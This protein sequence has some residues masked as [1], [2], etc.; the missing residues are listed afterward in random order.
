MDVQPD[1]KL[2]AVLQEVK[3]RYEKNRGYFEEKGRHEL[4]ARTLLVDPVLTALGWD[5]LDPSKVHLEQATS[6]DR[7]NAVDYALYETESVCT[8][9]VEAKNTGDTLTRTAQGQASLYADELGSTWVVL[10]N[11]LMWRGWMNGSVQE[12]GSMKM[13]EHVFLQI[14]ILSNPIEEC[15][16]QLNQISYERGRSIRLGKEN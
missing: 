6:A 4:R 11:G 8:G 1:A 14:S 12:R 15:C 9:V 2:R 3:E 5:V 10:T 16:Q 7:Q 13:G